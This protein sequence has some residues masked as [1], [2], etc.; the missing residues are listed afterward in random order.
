MIDAASIPVI[1]GDMDALAMHAR[2]VDA[3]GAGIADTGT[4]VDSTWQGLRPV[5]QA[6]EAEQLF[7]A[8]LVVKSVCASTGEAIQAAAA[9]L[10]RYSDEVRDIQARL[11]ALQGR[12]AEF[13][14]DMRLVEDPGSD[15]ATSTRT[16]SWSRR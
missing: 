12:A 2:A 4:D 11:R 14:A 3:A 7:A 1:E 6:P 5:Y 10:L 9:A 16:T 8:T 15:Q 13:E